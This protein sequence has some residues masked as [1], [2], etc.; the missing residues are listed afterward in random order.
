MKFLISWVL[1]LFKKPE[2]E[3][4]PWPLPA[5][6]KAQRKVAAKKVAA[7]KVAKKVVAKKTVAKKKKAT[8]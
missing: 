8:K 2:D 3:F 5:P 1:N 7:K 4:T 6:V